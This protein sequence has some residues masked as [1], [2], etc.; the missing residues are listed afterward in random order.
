MKHLKSI[1]LGLTLLIAWLPVQAASPVDQWLSSSEP[2]LTLNE[3]TEWKFA[4]PAPP[5]SHLPPVWQKGFDWLQA[6]TGDAFQLKVYGS[7][8]LYGM[9]GGFKAIRAGIADYGTCYT[10]TEATGFEL[11]KTFHLPHVAPANPYLTARIINELMATR[12]KAEFNRQGV[13]PAHVMPL[14]PLSLMSKEAIRVPE[15]LRGKKILSYMNAPGAAEALGYSEVNVPFPEIYS[16]L[17][18][19]LIDVVVW[20]DMG[21]IPF[22]IY[23]QAKFYTAIN[24][25][26]ATIETCFNRTSFDRLEGPLKQ[27]VYD[28]QQK[29]GISVVE[30]TEKFASS[31]RDTFV[32]NGVEIIELGNEQ[33]ALWKKAFEPSVEQWMQRCEQAGKDCRSLVTEIKQLEKKYSGLSD[34]EL[35]R[36]AIE[37]PVQ[38]IIE[39]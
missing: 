34:Q 16:A 7:G 1:C 19:G 30:A 23:E 13:Y 2:K 26:P 31:A 20:I 27:L 14:R 33:Q 17:Q 36:L 28:T 10:V 4:H 6:K 15:D 12:L 39:F 38:G 24:I 9:A 21:F 35:I 18:Q 3:K 11:Y 32:K 25:A 22:K 37:D 8:A 5:A 29:I